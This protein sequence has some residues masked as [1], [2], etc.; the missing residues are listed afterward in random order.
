M[1]MI[2]TQ[3]IYANPERIAAAAVGRGLPLA[4]TGA[5]AREPTVRGIL[6]SYCVNQEELFRRAVDALDRILRGAKAADIPV[7]QPLRYDFII[8]LKTARAMGLT[9][10][11]ALRLRA[12]ELI[13]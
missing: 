9:I 10:P 2:A 12:D 3:M 13:D 5:P 4:I 6:C 1:L 7:E 11:R 8:N